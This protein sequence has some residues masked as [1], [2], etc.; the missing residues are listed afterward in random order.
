MSTMV[1]E[2]LSWSMT[3]TRRFRSPS[4]R[5]LVAGASLVLTLPACDS[6][7]AGGSQSPNVELATEVVATGLDTV[8]ELAWGPDGFIWMTERGGRVSRVNPQTGAVTVIGQIAVNE[9][10]EGGLM[11]LAL[12]PDFATQPWVYLAHTYGAQGGVRNR[13]VRARFDGTSLGNPEVLVADIPGSSIHNGARL[14][15]GPDRL[16]YITTGDA[17]DASIA[18]NR[19]ALAGKVLRLTLDGQPAPGNPFGTRIYSYGHRNPQGMVFATDGSLY[20]TEHGPSDNDEVNRIEAGRNYGWPNVHGRCDGDSGPGELSFCSANNVAEPMAIWTPTIAPA[21]VA[22]Y[23]HTLIS[24]FRRS[25]IFATLKDATLY[26]LALSTDGRTV[27][28]TETLFVREFGRLRAVLV[29]PDGAIYLGTSNRDGRG[30]PM[31]TDDRIIRIR[32]R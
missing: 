13:V 18:Q 30:T 26:R 4:A 20:V 10:G 29:S 19:D 11:G 24:D 31:P 27:Q 8:W 7:T 12:H 23:D 6:A 1:R 28:S 9:I 22:Y 14:A 3:L 15:V 16:L 32:P 5:T 2:P 21:G 17:S 25:L